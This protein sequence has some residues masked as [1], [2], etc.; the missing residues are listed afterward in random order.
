VK[1]R[2]RAFVAILLNEEV[3]ARVADEI[4]RLRPLGRSVRWVPSENLHLTLRF[5]GERTPEEL[6]LVRDGLAEAVQGVTPFTLG[7]HGLGA[8]PGLARP[9]VFWVGA[10]TGANDATKLHARLEA[11][12]ARRTIP[13]EERPFSPHL[14]IGRARMPS[15]LAE[16]QQAIGR[17]AQK[18]FGDLPVRSISLMRSDLA[19]AGPRY[20]ELTTFPFGPE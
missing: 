4:A 19:P 18:S 20:A 12:L 14:T 16:L 10:A 15:G 13:P 3:R 6:E 2:V 1:A 7:F 8:F 17:E 9:R 11:A 5:L